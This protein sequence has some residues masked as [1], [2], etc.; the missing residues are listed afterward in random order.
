MGVVGE[1]GPGLHNIASRDPQQNLFK[2]W[3]V[4][5]VTSYTGDVHRGYS[6]VEKDDG[7]YPEADE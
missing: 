4:V 2:A 1:R 7:G 6:Y 3:L 5:P